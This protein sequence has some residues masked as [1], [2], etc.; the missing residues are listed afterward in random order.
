MQVEGKEEEVP[1]LLEKIK[2]VKERSP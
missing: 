1:D 2:E